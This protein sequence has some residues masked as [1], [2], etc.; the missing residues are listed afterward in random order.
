MK[1]KELQTILAKMNPDDDFNNCELFSRIIKDADVQ[2][3]RNALESL[4]YKTENISYDK[5][6]QMN[7]EANNE[8]ANY[9]FYNQIYNEV[10]SDI[11][12]KNDL[13]E[14]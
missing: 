2:D 12:D 8:L 1:I 9:D 13:E 4:G 3:F 10:I 6:N 14:L 7:D 5:L 11:A